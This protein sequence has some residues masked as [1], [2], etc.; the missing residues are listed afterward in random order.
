MSRSRRARIAALPL[1]CIAT[2][3]LAQEAEEPSILVVGQKDAPIS[4]DPRGL[5]VS[6]GD[7]QFA[8][9][10]AQ[11]VE[12]LMKYA[13]DFFVRKRYAGDSNGVPGFRG[14][15]SMQSARALVMVDGFVVSNLLGNSFAYA[16]KWGVVGPGEVEQ[17]DVVYGPY[18]ARYSGNSMG[19]IVNIATRSPAKTEA[20]ATVQGL[21]EP[22]DQYG[23]RDTYWGWSGEAGLGWRQKDGPWSARLSGRHFRN[24]GQPMSWYGLT[25]ATGAAGTVVTG[26]VVDPGQAIPNAPGTASNPIFAA[27]S[28]AATTQDQAKLRIGYDGVSGITGE[29][30]FAYWHN[31]DAQYAPDCYLR[32]SAGNKVCEGR[33]TTL[34]QT[35][36]A[37]GAKWS[38]T[39]RDEYLAGAK[40]A[41]PL[42][43]DVTARLNVS[44][45]QVARSDGFTSAS[46]AAGAANGAGT[47]AR[48][49]PT[50]WYTAEAS[51]DG[52]AGALDLAAGASANLYQT[53]LTNYAVPNWRADDGRAFSTRTFGKTRL[54]AG[55][56]EGRLRADAL[57]FTLGAR[58]ESWRAFD[59]GLGRV[60][61]NGQPVTNRYAARGDTAFDPKFSVEWHGGATSV[62]LSL[63]EATRFPTVGE[64][65]QG[66]LNGDG[67]FN[68]NSF[69][70]DLKPERSRDANLLVAHDFGKLK[71]T[72]SAFWQRVDDTIFSF[73]GFNQNGITTSTFKNI[74]VTRQVGLE[75]IA[76][77]RDVGVRGLD[78]DANVAWIDSETVRNDAA[79]AAEGVQFPRIPRWRLNANIRYQVAPRVLASLGMRYATRPNTDLFGTQRGD[80]FGY[81]SELFA[82]DAKVNWKMTETLRLSVGVDNI[83]NDRAWVYHPYPQRSF[84]VEAGWTL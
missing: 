14:T 4:I 7:E 78:L 35:W 84:L 70:P 64:L 13:P 72:G 32:D 29:M 55:W 18:S 69:D 24:T 53:D 25:P 42:G 58:F 37:S 83:T 62:Q 63:A 12:D 80:T 75:L 9:V 41:A 36:N 61:T 40:I 43:E 54:L 31:L 49:G 15:H 28:P 21:A 1:L 27:Q 10:N 8:G 20:F 34:G 22:F 77:A 68:A 11:N 56:A 6:L 82:L 45:Y 3:A 48:Q 46:Y 33:V 39:V 81:T 51:L 57:V 52:K 66:S 67:S 71:L 38:R 5:S 59:G 26:A 60:G 73:I 16:P 19:G 44:T 17:F 65:F 23:T 30:L 76:E 50:G 2:P 47:L 79:P 74:D